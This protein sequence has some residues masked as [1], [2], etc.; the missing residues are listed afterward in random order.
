MNK[1]F[2]CYITIAGNPKPLFRVVDADSAAEAKAKVKKAA[3]EKISNA[4]TYSDFIELNK[5]LNLGIDI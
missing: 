3:E 4:K 1:L 5:I 2:D